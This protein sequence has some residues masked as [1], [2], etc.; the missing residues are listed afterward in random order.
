[1]VNEPVVS[2]VTNETMPVGL[3]PV[4][5]TMQGVPEP[6]VG[7]LA[8]NGGHDTGDTWGFVNAEVKGIRDAKT[9]SSRPIDKT[10]VLVFIYSP[11][12]PR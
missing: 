1:V 3:F 9:T 11:S 6:V 12:S 10:M 5:D 7:T 8:L 4:T 2:D